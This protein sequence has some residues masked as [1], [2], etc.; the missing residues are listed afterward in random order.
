MKKPIL[1]SLMLVGL[2]FGSAAFAV[3]DAEMTACLQ[4]HGQLMQKP[5]LRNMIACWRAHGYLMSRR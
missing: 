1:L 4:A 2:A 5:A 3:T